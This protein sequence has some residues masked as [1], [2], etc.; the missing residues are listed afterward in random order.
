[1]NVADYFFQAW[2]QEFSDGVADSSE[3]GAKI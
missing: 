2:S 1:M 3:E